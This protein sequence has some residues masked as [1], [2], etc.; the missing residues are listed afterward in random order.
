MT[1]FQVVNYEQFVWFEHIS[2]IF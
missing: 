1:E 2:F